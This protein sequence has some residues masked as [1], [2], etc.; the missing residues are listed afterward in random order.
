VA[1]R[2]WQQA[3]AHLQPMTQASAQ[4]SARPLAAWLVLLRGVLGLQDTTPESQ[5]EDGNPADPL[6]LWQDAAGTQVLA[7]LHLQ[8]GGEGD[9][10]AWRQ[11]AA[12]LPMTLSGFMRW[13]ASTLQELPFLPLWRG[14]CRRRAGLIETS[15]HLIAQPAFTRFALF[16]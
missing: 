5:A 12:A 6:P 11:A 3:Q 2:L 10:P 1:Q 8:R 15:S 4:N 14:F 13:V 16:R 9:T 7:A